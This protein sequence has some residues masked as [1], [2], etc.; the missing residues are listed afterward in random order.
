[1]EGPT[2]KTK[3]ALQQTTEDNLAN[4]TPAKSELAKGRLDKL[5]STRRLTTRERNRVE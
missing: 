4:D 1:M 5:N 3:I 2:H